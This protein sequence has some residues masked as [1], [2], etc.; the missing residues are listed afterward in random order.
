ME[1]DTLLQPV[2]LDS[3]RCGSDLTF[4]LEFDA[5]REARRSDDP[6]LAQGEWV[7]PIKDAQWDKVTLICQNILIE[8]SKDVRVAAW[9]AESLAKTDGLNGLAF[10]YRLLTRLCEIYWEDIHP[11]FDD[12]G[13]EQRVGALDWLLSQS[14]QWIREMPLTHSTRGAFSLIDLESARSNTR[15]NERYSEQADDNSPSSLTTEIFEAA[16]I[17]TPSSHFSANLQAALDVQQAMDALQTT[18]VMVLAEQA[19]S[20]GPAV[21]ALDNVIRFL[22]RYAV[23][24]KIATGKEKKEAPTKAESAVTPVSQTVTGA[25]L[26]REQAISQLQEIAVFFR[27]SEPHSPVAYLADKAARW[28][29]MPLHEWLRNVVRDDAALS[30][31][32][33]LLGVERHSPP[34]SNDA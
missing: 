25:I 2:T 24:T 19:P 21:D 27:R 28:G 26:S 23:E 20:F 7:T 14:T 4:S 16:A 11:Q 29:S 15:N 10:G 5:I 8:K 34:E 31:V 17:E 18:L 33:E 6:S 12:D 1:L 32:E 22:R 30:H 3:E 13:P 9:L